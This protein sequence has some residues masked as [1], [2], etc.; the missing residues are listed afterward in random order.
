MSMRSFLDSKQVLKGITFGVVD[1]EAIEHKME[2]TLRHH[3]V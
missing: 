2:N 3:K 1:W